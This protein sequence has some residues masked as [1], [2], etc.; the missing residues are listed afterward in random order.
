MKKGFKF[1]ILTYSEITDGDITSIIIDTP[2]VLLYFVNTI[3]IATYIINIHYGY[4]VVRIDSDMID[5][6]GWTS[7][8]VAINTIYETTTRRTFFL[9]VLSYVSVHFPGFYHQRI[10]L[11]RIC[12]TYE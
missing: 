9:K 11:L 1:L 4:T 6:V 7:E 12:A 8:V 10:I 5:I 2:T 3:G